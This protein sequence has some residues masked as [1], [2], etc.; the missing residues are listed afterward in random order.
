VPLWRL[1]H[2]LFIAPS[3]FLMLRCERWP[4]A[5]RV[6][7]A[8]AFLT[9][10]GM[11]A[12]RI[13]R[14][15]ADTSHWAAWFGQEVGAF[16]VREGRLYWDRP[17]VLPYTTRHR[18]WRIDFVPDGMAFPARIGPETR[19]VWLAP[20]HVYAWR[21]L[22]DD[23]ALLIP[24][25][26]DRGR[27]PH[28]DLRRLWP[29]GYRLEGHA[30][31]AEARRLML[32]LFPF[33]I[34]YKGVSVFLQVLFYTALFALAPLLFR[35]AVVIAGQPF[36]LAFYF[37][38]AV[39]PLLVAAVYASLDLPHLDYRLAF[40]LGFFVYLFMVIRSTATAVAPA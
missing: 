33:F 38:A 26:P 20:E 34:L 30:F 21:R 13:P 19:G 5:F 10:A 11:G 6:M 29:D 35:R 7:A 8:T 18:Q 39:P 37:Y 3:R 25:L 22:P 31:P 40:V 4:R 23:K 15:L 27:T 36:G 2:I 12:A 9:G 24:L 14:I 28:F 32:R 17:E 1:L 16:E